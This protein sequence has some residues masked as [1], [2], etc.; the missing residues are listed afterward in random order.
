[1]PV[2]LLQTG[3]AAVFVMT[4]P[5]VLAAGNES[6]SPVPPAQREVKVDD[7]FSSYKQPDSPG[8]AV[9]IYSRG[10]L[11]Y[12][13]GYGVADREHDI[14]IGPESV[15]NLASVSKQFT[16]FSIALLARQRKLSLDSDI[17][18]YLPSFPDVGARITVD[19]LIHHTSGIR[20]YISFGALAGYDDASL[21]RQAQVVALLER[22]TALNFVP[23]TQYEYS[24]AGYVLLAQIVKS[25]TGQSLGDFERRN[26][27]EPLG[28]EHTRVRSELTESIPALAVGYR[29]GATAG[30]WTRAV[31][32]REVVGP[33]NVFSTVGDLAKWAANFMHPRVGD[34]A[35]VSQVTAQGRLLDGS[36]LNYGFGVHHQQFLGHEAIV[37]TGSVPGFTSM[38]TVFPEEDFAVVLL[39]NLSIPVE[40]YT[41]KIAALYLGSAKVTAVSLPQPV[42]PAAALLAALQGQYQTPNGQVLSLKVSGATLHGSTASA[43][44]GAAIFSS[45]GTFRFPSF[46]E[47]ERLRPLHS[48]DPTLSALETVGGKDRSPAHEPRY[49]RLKATPPSEPTLRRLVGDYHSDEIDRTFSI[50]VQQGRLTLSSAWIP[51]PQILVPTRAR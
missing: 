43:D 45:D 47:D 11:I 33:G 51:E 38:V 1:M 10:K 20:D 13:K 4:G 21:L 46:D 3:V 42:E 37:H 35:L 26:I 28:M 32:N 9:G 2:Y 14:P 30:T 6:G 19:N 17:R 40:S 50:G 12:V 23:G 34:A 36:V 31:Y 25:V 39:A 29:H 16:A 44:M 7:L 18:T 49:R 48:D 41:E 15:F 24:N 27:F 5:A 8:V 22:Q